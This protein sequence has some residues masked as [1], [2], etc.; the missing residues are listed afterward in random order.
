MIDFLIT[1]QVVLA[2]FFIV[3]MINV[4]QIIVNIINVLERDSNNTNATYHS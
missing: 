3:H 1:L 4:N 2:V